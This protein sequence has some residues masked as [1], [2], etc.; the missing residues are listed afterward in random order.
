MLRSHLESPAMC[1]VTHMSPQTQNELIEIMGKHIVLRGIVEELKE[2]KYFAI[3]ADEVT[4]HNVEHLA[5]CARFVDCHNNICEEFLVFIALERITGNQIADAI[6][7]FL[8][9][10]DIPLMTSS[11]KSVHALAS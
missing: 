3:L 9:E 10:N 7:K 4:S 1:C 11:K 2:A 8:E 5:I 6:L